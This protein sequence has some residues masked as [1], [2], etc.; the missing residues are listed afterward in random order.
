ML[1]YRMHHQ[2]ACSLF[3]ACMSMHRLQP[4][5]TSIACILAW[6]VQEDLYSNQHDSLYFI[7][8]ALSFQPAN[9][10]SVS[11]LKAESLGLLSVS[12]IRATRRPMFDEKVPENTSAPASMSSSTLRRTTASYVCKAIAVGS[13]RFPDVDI[14]VQSASLGD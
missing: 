8:F 12:R 6:K 4:T 3:L 5:L 7:T 2:R 11:A 13:E 9:Q 14:R 10:F 1:D